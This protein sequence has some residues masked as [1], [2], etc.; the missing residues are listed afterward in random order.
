MSTIFERPLMGELRHEL[1]ALR[2]NWLWFVVLG[3]ALVVLGM[4]AL[5]SVVIASL[6]AAVAIGALLLIGGG[7]EVVGAFWCRGWSG[8]F[9]HLLSGVLSIVVGL[10]FL[11]APVGALAA[12]TLLIACFLMVGGIFKTVAALGYR[13]AAWG[14]ALAGGII[15]LI[16][17]VLIWQEWPAS[18]LWVIGLFVGINLLF[19]GFN[20]IA[21]GMA[22]CTTSPGDAMRSAAESHNDHAK[23]ASRHTG[24]GRLVGALL[25]AQGEPSEG[26]ESMPRRRGIVIAALL[27]AVLALL[28]PLGRAQVHGRV[29]LLL[30]L[31]A[32][33][34]IAHGLRRATAQWAAVG[35]VRRRHHAGH[36]LAAH[37]RAV[38]R[39][40]GALALPGRVVRLWTAFA[41]SLD[42]LQ[43]ARKG[44]FSLL[45]ILA[46]L[47][48]FVAALVIFALR[49][50]GRGMDGGRRRGR[51]DPGDGLEHFR[52]ARL[53]CQR[54][55][56]HGHRRPRPGG[57]S[58]DGR[59]C[60]A[61]RRG[62][63]GPGTDRPWVDP[64][65]PGDASG[66]PRRPH[67]LRSYLPG[68]HRPRIRRA[69]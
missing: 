56:G 3:V 62:G 45:G 51:P 5:G 49:R 33:F 65:L 25:R 14:W 2:G 39:G 6:A 58:R 11:R 22:L 66:D 24:L 21:L 13:F 57:Q 10:L 50:Q 68:D 8:F 37:Q 7:A 52:L 67:G 38:P 40:R 63:G 20:W 29:G 19:R 32:A 17:G 46:C 30:V 53:H 23:R 41:I 48:N 16:L 54:Y 18:A 34:E 1:N 47:G 64:R 15:D 28:A 12:L 59:T 44:R 9:L 60:S 26:S 42:T 43:I 69:R 4:V 35:V 36:G 27:L 55:R 31:A 61:A